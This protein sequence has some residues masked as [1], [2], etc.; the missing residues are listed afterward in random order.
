MNGGVFSLV[1]NLSFGDKKRGPK[2]RADVLT[3]VPATSKKV[4]V[5]ILRT[6]CN[7]FLKTICYTTDT[8]SSFVR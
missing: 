3:T 2:A 8:T 5:I 6:A 4:K 7:R 1:V